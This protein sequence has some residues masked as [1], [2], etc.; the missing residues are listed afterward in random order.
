[1][2]TIFTFIFIGLLNQTLAQDT[3][4]PTETSE[5]EK[6][7][8]EAPTYDAITKESVRF[9]QKTNYRFPRNYSEKGESTLDVKLTISKASYEQ[10][11]KIKLKVEYLTQKEGS[12]KIAP[13]E[14]YISK[15][16]ISN[17][18]D[19][20]I[21]SVNLT[22]PNLKE[23]T[24]KVFRLELY[25][26]TLKDFADRRVISV[27]TKRDIDY[28]KLLNQT[29]TV[30]LG[31]LTLDP[32][33]VQAYRRV[34][35]GKRKALI[36]RYDTFIMN[37]GNAKVNW[38][39]RWFRKRYVP[40]N[41]AKELSIQENAEQKSDSNPVA[42]NKGDANKNK[43]DNAKIKVKGSGSEKETIIINN[44]DIVIAEGRMKL[45]KVE[46]NHGTYLNKGPVSLTNFYARRY[47][48]LHYSGH[49]LDRQSSYII[50]GDILN[51]VERTGR[52]YFPS[53]TSFR[54]D[55]SHEVEHLKS[56]ESPLTFLDGRIYTDPKG[57]S[58]DANGLVQTEI[59]AR[60][61]LNSNA[62]GRS[63]MTFA[64]NLDMNFYVSKFDSDHDTLVVNTFEH[65]SAN[66]LLSIMRNS[67]LGFKLEAD[68]IR[69]SRVHDVYW[70]VGHNLLHTK[71]RDTN[72]TFKRVITP[73]FF[74]TLGG[75]LHVSP[76]INANFEL[77]ISFAYSYDQPFI[78]YR[79]RFEW[80]IAPEVEVTF[81]LRKKKDADQKTSFLFAR[82]RYYDMPNFARNN[83]YQIQLGVNFPIT[84]MFK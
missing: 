17:C 20:L 33:G 82:I 15:E 23:E 54:L 30:I 52:S 66:D 26:D 75:T 13:S 73:I 60:F 36:A 39:D 3:I 27:Y 9:T 18:N 38:R 16:E 2:R 41:D 55:E 21:T 58:G 5:P 59:N 8:S 34:K 71:V 14:F 79:N 68:L 77:P 4:V 24:E 49:E 45:I 65:R 63:Y 11:L 12:V 40:L 50:L 69:G 56:F 47:Y 28:E 7:I 43:G 84:G 19:S 44:V 46:T 70:T 6:T 72:S 80:F 81:D 78:N 37:N 64:Q 51:Y 1:M 32:N 74:T 31:S 48:R 35:H 62:V 10:N 53:S 25:V 22:I 42:S 57:L 76:R 61:I 83:Y 29:D 67:N